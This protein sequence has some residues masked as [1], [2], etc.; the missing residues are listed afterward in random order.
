MP[1]SNLHKLSAKGVSVWID[2]LSRD[3]LES[4]ELE[5]MMREDAALGVA[6]ADRVADLLRL[7]RVVDALGVGVGAEVDD[8]V[9]R[10]RFEHGGSEVVGPSLAR[11][12]IGAFLGA[13]FDGGERYVKRLKKIEDLE[14]RALEV[15]Q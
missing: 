10:E 13:R 6:G 2:Y 4:G 1:D 9:A 14:R 7:V 11:D 5:R 15:S 8:V 3:L 12:L